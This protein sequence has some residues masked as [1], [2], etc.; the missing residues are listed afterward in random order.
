[1]DSGSP[2]SPGGHGIDQTKD[3]GLPR[4]I[5]SGKNFVIPTPR[6]GK[7]S[8]DL[9]GGPSHK[10]EAAVPGARWAC[11]VRKANRRDTAKGGQHLAELIPRMTRRRRHRWGVDPVI[12]SKKS[13]GCK[14]MKFMNNKEKEHKAIYRHSV[15]M[16][17]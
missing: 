17:K 9:T 14:R 2:T 6:R 8:S 10:E 3:S 12:V 5:C 13:Q 7:P 4:T 11:G 1:M 16:G 15:Q